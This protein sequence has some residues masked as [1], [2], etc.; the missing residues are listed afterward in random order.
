MI[1][2]LP[3]LYRV[4]LDRLC[5]WPYGASFEVYHSVRNRNRVR[6]LSSAGRW[7]ESE[8]AD[9]WRAHGG[10]EVTK[11]CDSPAES[12]SHPCYWLILISG[13]QWLYYCCHN[14]AA[15]GLPLVNNVAARTSTT[16]NAICGGNTETYPIPSQVVRPATPQ[17]SLFE[18]TNALCL[19]SGWMV[20]SCFSVSGGMNEANGGGDRRELVALSFLKDPGVTLSLGAHVSAPPSLPLRLL[21]EKKYGRRVRKNE[22]NYTTARL[23]AAPSSSPLL[24]LEAPHAPRRSVAFTGLT[25]STVRRHVGRLHR[26]HGGQ[27]CR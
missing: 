11:T 14:A 1:G 18:Q 15:R 9:L 13:K 25:G 27:D 20:C 24:Q 26:G 8:S 16:N 23:L 4:E 12:T 3:T 2:H 21:C 19:I 22:V 17:T 6:P 7:G 10:F 5:R